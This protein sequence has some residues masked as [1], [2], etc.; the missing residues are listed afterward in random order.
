M[1]RV[2]AIGS[3]IAVQ[4]FALAGAVVRVIDDR[5][6]ALSAWQDLPD[7]VAVVVLSAETAAAL[8]TEVLDQ[9]RPLIVVL[10]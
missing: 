8:P 10:P 7:D 4:G 9:D 5:T 6:S 3:A 2:A 1:A